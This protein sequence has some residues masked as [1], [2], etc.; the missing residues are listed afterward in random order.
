MLKKEKRWIGVL[1]VLLLFG[2]CFGDSDSSSNSSSNSGSNTTP[3]SSSTV[4]V[5]GTLSSTISKSISKSVSQTNIDG[6]S[7]VSA[8]PTSGS[9]EPKVVALESDDSRFL[10]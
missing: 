5:S 3:A 6:I 9:S 4:K 7:Y 8:I 10:S 2:G 1:F